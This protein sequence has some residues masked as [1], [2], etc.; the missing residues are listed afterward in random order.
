MLRRM[1][2]WLL[3]LS[4]VLNGI[5]SAMAGVSMHAGKSSQAHVVSM[6]DESDSDHPSSKIAHGQ[7]HVGNHGKASVTGNCDDDCCRD[8]GSCQCLCMQHA[9]AMV[10][11]PI[12]FVSPVS[13]IGVSTTLKIGH[14]APPPGEQIR[15]P[16]G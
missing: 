2:P 1:L 13:L 10:S 6:H 5:S 4:L 7:D 8:P 11:G 16:I 14:P 15:P 3:A 12:G 9:Q